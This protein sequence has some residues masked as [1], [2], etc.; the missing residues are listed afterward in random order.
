[1]MPDMPKKVWLEDQSKPDNDFNRRRAFKCV[2][3]EDVFKDL[4]TNPAFQ[5][6]NQQMMRQ[7]VE[8]DFDTDNE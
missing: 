3:D 8:A 1:M 5:G 7:N 2:S 6:L 4:Y